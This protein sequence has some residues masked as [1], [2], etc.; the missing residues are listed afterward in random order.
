MVLF[1]VSPLSPQ[2]TTGVV[3]APAAPDAGHPIRVEVADRGGRRTAT[4]LTRDDG[5][6]AAQ[7][8]GDVLPVLTYPSGDVAY[9]SGQLRPTLWVFSALL[10]MAGGLPLLGGLRARRRDRDAPAPTWSAR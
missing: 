7:G 10:T 2:P 5:G 8:V 4:L 9:D 1:L 6:V 3:V